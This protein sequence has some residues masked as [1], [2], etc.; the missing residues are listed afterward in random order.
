[1]EEAAFITYLLY[2]C[3]HEVLGDKYVCVYIF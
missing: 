3:D 2:A 1:M